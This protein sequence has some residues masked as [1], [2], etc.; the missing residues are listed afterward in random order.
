ML[1]H[2]TW[3]AYAADY[4]RVVAYAAMALVWNVSDAQSRGAEGRVWLDLADTAARRIPDDLQ[5]SAEVANTRGVLMQDLGDAD[6]AREAFEQ[7]LSLLEGAEGSEALAK[8]GALVN[9]AILESEV[10]RFEEAYTLQEQALA[11]RET[12]EGRAHPRTATLL[13]NMSTVL[14]ALGR[15]EEAKAAN[16]EALVQLRARYGDAH[17]LVGTALVQKATLVFE[18]GGQADAVELLRQA[19]KVFE[20]AR[21]RQHRDLAIIYINIGQVEL[22]LGNGGAAVAAKERALEIVRANYEP[23]SDR[24]A[25]AQAELAKAVRRAE[26]RP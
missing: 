1:R 12:F 13:N 23:G 10:G 24:V 9:L 18:E 5:L 15:H 26:S 25:L 22:D 2:A 11:L 8:A 4:H 6:A 19:A 16:A 3:T 7:V 17:P 14:V 20:V 21:G